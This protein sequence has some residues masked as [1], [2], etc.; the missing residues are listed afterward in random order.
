VLTY[1]AIDDAGHRTTAAIGILVGVPPSVP[2]KQTTVLN[3][4]SVVIGLP[5]TGQDSRP[6]TLR[7]IGRPQHGTAVINADG[8]V[9]YVPD[10]G[11]TGTDSFTYEV[12]DADGNV[13]AATVH[14]IVPGPPLPVPTT[15]A[16]A[17]STSPTPSP[18]ASPT[19][20]PSAAPTPLPPATPSPSSGAPSTTPP[21]AP[22]PSPSTLNRPPIA[23]ADTAVVTDG[24]GVVIRP[25]L[26][27]RD[28]D[29]DRVSVVAIR[30]ARVGTT[31]MTATTVTYTAAADRPGTVEVVGYTIGD[32]RGG[33]A[34][35]TIRI[36]VMPSTHMPVT[37]HDVLAAARAGLFA[38][39]AGGALYWLAG[40]P[41]GGRRADRGGGR[42]RA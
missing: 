35:A 22:V 19:P 38:V 8:T 1:T 5:V 34:G 25:L 41:G 31:T 17:P 15:T 32:G 39:A 6:V 20:S 36:E 16:P 9:T 7:R 30:K 13:A 2:N 24:H 42:H 21:G 10:R 37:G 3:G 12:V 27:D 33:R 28:P 18:S 14:V 23:A 26:N 4:R 40:R 11:F 29:G